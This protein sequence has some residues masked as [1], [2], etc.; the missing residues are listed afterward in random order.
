M[1]ATLVKTAYS[2]TIS[3]SKECSNALFTESGLLVTTD[4]PVHLCSMAETA[5][6]ILDYFQYDLTGEDL[7]LTNDPYS[8][9]TRIQDFTI[10]APL[11]HEDEIVLYVGTRAHLTDIGGDLLGGY[12]PKAT[13]IWAEG[14][15]FT[16]VKLYRDGRLQKDI[17]T[18]IALNS[19]TPDALK[20]DL[21]AM[22]AAL[23]VGRRRLG[24]LI[25]AYGIA[26]VLDAMDWAIEYAERRFEA[27]IVSWP[28]GEFEGQSVLPHD[29]QG[30][31]DLTIRTTV[32]IQP[33]Q[34]EL[35]FSA[36]DE[37]ST[38]FV[39]STAATTYACAVLPIFSAIDDSVPKNAGVLRRV[40]LITN[41]GTLV[42]AQFPGPTAWSPHH[43]GS[44][45]ANSVADAL[46]KF[47]PDRA[48]TVT[49]NMLLVNTI[50]RGVRHGATVEQLERCNYA[51][52]TQGGCSG[53][54]GRDGWGMPGVFAESPLPS[55]ELHEADFGGQITKMEFVTD[56]GGS[57]KWRGGVGT[58]TRIELPRHANDLYLTT[59]VEAL[60]PGSDGFL[61]GG[62]GSP[63]AVG[64]VRDGQPV[65]VEQHLTDEQIPPG[66][67]I[68]LR[69]GG[70]AGW[71]HASERNPALVL[72][73][74]SSGYVS[75][76]AAARDYRV[77]IDPDTLTIDA[78]A[79]RRARSAH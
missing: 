59:C 12:N 77:I 7:I 15:R 76:E 10:L 2:A 75:V 28:Q 79:T 63:N 70:G 68:H 50:E 6:S 49:A 22:V 38:G 37:Q 64:V 33:G 4:N 13:E 57:G 72:A 25:S 46:A 65:P 53:A 30:R 74:V 8:G 34:L 44:E 39:N 56:S 32:R 21:D 66:T 36:T 24:E 19:R 31:H 3:E 67:E 11:T 41:K 78:E 42:D 35:D 73:D 16:P 40:K 27:E 45:I 43:V 20:L 60:P 9:G 29:C 61:G 71:G 1:R 55:V 26:T 69:M 23:N 47:L 14:G 54:E 48:A 18:T 5:A 51:R 62:S 17:L 52:F 58:E